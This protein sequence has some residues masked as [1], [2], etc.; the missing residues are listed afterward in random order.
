MVWG[1]P[2]VSSRRVPSDR[3]AIVSTED[4]GDPTVNP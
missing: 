4:T 3:R 2:V 1:T